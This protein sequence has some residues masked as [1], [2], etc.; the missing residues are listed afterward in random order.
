MA[1][2]ASATVIVWTVI[3]LQPHQQDIT[4]GRKLFNTFMIFSAIGLSGRA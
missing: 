1:V 3:E 2:L 4:L